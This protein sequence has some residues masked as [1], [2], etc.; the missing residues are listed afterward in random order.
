VVVRRSARKEGVGGLWYL[1]AHQR[2]SRS[3]DIDADDNLEKHS[4]AYPTEL[5]SLA[6]SGAPVRSEK[7][8]AYRSAVDNGR[9]ELARLKC[10]AD[11]I[12]AQAM[13]T[14]KQV[15]MAEAVSRADCNFSPRV[16][17]PYWL[18]EVAGGERTILCHL[19]PGDWTAGPP[20]GY[21]YLGKVQQLPTGLWEVLD[22]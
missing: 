3:M 8:L 4:L 2:S 9:R 6:F 19:G 21:R 12:A 1:Q 7:D 15:E 20:E 14:K 17:R 10:L 13:E 16:G 11:L 22:G 18:A 5:G